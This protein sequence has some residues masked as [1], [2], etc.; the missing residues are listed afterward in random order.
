MFF[1]KGLRI[2][3]IG[4]V[5]ISID[6]SWFVIFALFVFLLGSAYLPVVAPGIWR[7][8]YWVAAVCTT[9]LFFL[10]VVVHEMAHSV[11]ARHEGIPVN[12]ITL[13]LFG[14]V[15]QMEDEPGTPSDEFRMA[16]AGP[17][18]SVGVAVVFFV[19]TLG[20]A[21]FHSRIIYASFTYL[22][23]I[24]LALA[25]F[26]LI[27]AYPMDG[28]RV[29]RAIVWGATHDFRRA[30]FIASV[31]G[32]TFGW[33][34]IVLGVGSIFLPSIRNFAS[35]WLALIGWFIISAARSSYQQVLVRDT[36]SKV[37]IS[38]V[39]NSNVEAVDGNISVERLVTDYFL[40]ESASTLPVEH[41]R[42][43]RAG[44]PARRPGARRRE[45]RREAGHRGPA[46]QRGRRAHLHV[47]RRRSGG[48]RAGERDAVQPFHQRQRAGRRR[49]ERGLLR[50]RGHHRVPARLHHRLER[51]DDDGARGTAAHLGDAQPR[52]GRRVLHADVV[53]RR[54]RPRQG[55]PQRLQRRPPAR[56]GDHGRESHE[57]ERAHE[58]V[59]A[60]PHRRVPPAH[61]RVGGVVTLTGKH[62]LKRGG[63][64]E[65][66]GRTATAVVSWSDTAIEV[67]VP[68]GTPRG[69]VRA[70][71][72]TVIGRSA[73]GYFVRL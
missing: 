54:A 73:P 4:G 6:Y 41:P 52:H 26:N 5:T 61:G 18:A 68:A 49:P 44:R 69:R 36:L 46:G 7:G 45:P 10:S 66:G 14:G 8:W 48:V 30:T 64:V 70:T 27:P 24:N 38:D 32:Q 67:R 42:D 35:I 31:T 17:L 25:I 13:F 39:M 57:R 56:P 15:S 9:L 55:A 50:R 60:G 3:R 40:R 12:N 11:V 16:I 43:R 22:W 2:G 23:F 65:F 21:A 62:F 63:T 47:P 37:P 53:P 1:G 59:L 34:L 28:G 20:A 29:F 51:Q 58:R 19:L 71:V 72:T 33:I